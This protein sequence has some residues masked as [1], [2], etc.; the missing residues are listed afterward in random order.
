MII[1]IVATIKFD[2]T[3]KDINNKTLNKLGMEA[4]LMMLKTDIKIP[5]T[6]S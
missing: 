6:Y 2:S 4:N 1:K 3:E 5:K